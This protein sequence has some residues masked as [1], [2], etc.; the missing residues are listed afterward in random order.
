MSPFYETYDYN[1]KT[2][3]SKS[4]KG[5]PSQGLREWEDTNLTSIGIFYARGTR[6]NFP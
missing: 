6:M 1:S 3:Y 4:L 2:D 5:F